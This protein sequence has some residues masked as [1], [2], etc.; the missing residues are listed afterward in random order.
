MRVQEMEEKLFMTISMRLREK[1]ED[2]RVI[3]KNIV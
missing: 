3:K 2:D 1:A